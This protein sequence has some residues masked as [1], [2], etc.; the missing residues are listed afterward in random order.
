M[1]STYSTNLRLELIGT[2]EQQGT[3]GSTT[4]KNLGTLLEQAICG[5][6]SVTV[7]DAGDTT[8]TASNGLSDQSRNMVIN[9]TGTLTGSRNVICP[10]VEKLYVV[11]NATSG[12]FAVT[13]KVSGQTGVSV[14]NG[15]TVFVYVDGVDARSITGSIASQAA[16]N[17]AITGGS[18]TG[19][20]NQTITANSSGDALRITQT[21]SGN[22]FVVEDSATPDA[23]PFYINSNGDLFSSGFMTAIT[24]LTSGNSAS[25]SF[26]YIAPEGAME[27]SRSSGDAFIDFKT[28]AAEDF[29]ARIMQQ[30]NGLTF[31]TGGDGSTSERVRISA[32][33]ALGIAGANYGTSGQVLTSGGSSASPSWTSLGTAATL[34][35]GTSANNVVQLDGT[36][37]LP[38]VDGSQLT[39]LPATASGRLLRAPQILTSGTSYTTPANCTSIYVELVGGGGGG[40]GGNISASG[41]GGGGAYAAKYFTVT[42][43]TAYTYAIGAG[44]T[45]NSGAGG[46][47]TFTVGATTV[48]AGGGG[49]GGTSG[50]TPPTSAAGGGGGTA[51]NGDINVSGGSGNRGFSDASYA[52]VFTGSGGV[53]GLGF[54]AGGQSS[55]ASSNATLNG[56][57]ASGYGGGG[58]GGQGT[59]TGGDGT[60]GVIRVWEYA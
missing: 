23:T 26:V 54:G 51:T 32:D 33:G 38:A 57:N 44:A 35:V 1:A 37:K 52:T 15:S 22:A 8:L 6:E 2:G 36:A 5:Y 42:A 40:G 50:S 14:P 16:S 9:L 48:T 21:G 4:N 24:G 49:G 13:F 58:G 59:G 46:N 19:I 55:H 28:S 7:S 47:T 39:N 25:N 60:S 27:L 17:V 29:D 45:A 11:K 12:G 30:S 31:W 20:S 10:A 56:S 53:S 41:G 34:N 18:I 43:S 3:W